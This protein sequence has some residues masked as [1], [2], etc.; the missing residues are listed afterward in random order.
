MAMSGAALWAGA[1]GLIFWWRRAALCCLVG[2]DIFV[3]W[4]VVGV[5]RLVPVRVV[6]VVVVAATRS[7]CHDVTGA[8]VRDGLLKS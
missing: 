7:A 6:V 2:A 1:A 8:P 4:F 3:A 5:G